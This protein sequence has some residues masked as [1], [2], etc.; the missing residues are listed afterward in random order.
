MVM[1]Q[2][3]PSWMSD[4]LMKT[5]SI[6]WNDLKTERAHNTDCPLAIHLECH[7]LWHV[8]CACFPWSAWQASA[9]RHFLLYHCIRTSQ[10]SC[11]KCLP[12]TSFWQFVQGSADFSQPLSC[13]LSQSV[14]PL[15]LVLTA[16]FWLHL[17]N[18]HVLAVHCQL[19]FFSLIVLDKFIAPSQA[20]RRTMSFS[21]SLWTYKVSF[22]YMP[23][24]LPATNKTS[25]SH[26][27]KCW[28]LQVR[29]VAGRYLA[30]IV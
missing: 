10:W 15:A 20:S 12:P 16:T 14:Y 7:P 4:K 30:G 9:D 2:I 13:E 23:N 26:W 18:V 21:L 17:T 22:I 25:L 29:L 27:P 24:L 28:I 1:L 11:S 19:R 8:S 6:L 5:K 3:G